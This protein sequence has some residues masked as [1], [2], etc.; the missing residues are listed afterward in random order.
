[1]TDEEGTLYLGQL[2]LAE[3]NLLSCTAAWPRTARKNQFSRHRIQP[4]RPGKYNICSRIRV[5]PQGKHPKILCLQ[6]KWAFNT[7]DF[8]PVTISHWNYQATIMLDGFPI[9]VGSSFYS[10]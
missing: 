4:K 9:L 5:K 1:M 3:H 6:C 10:H 7:L 8:K 2:N